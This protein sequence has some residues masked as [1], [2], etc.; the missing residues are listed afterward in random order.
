MKN[1]SGI[2]VIALIIIIAIMLIL[3]TI[4]VVALSGDNSLINKAGEAKEDA[5]I[6]NEKDIINLAVTTVMNNNEF[7][8]LVADDLAAE[9]N[10]NYEDIIDNV[11]TSS[12]SVQVKFKSG[13]M[14]LVSTDGSLIQPTDRTGIEVG[15]YVDYTPDVASTT[16]YP[17]STLDTYSG[18]TNNSADITQD[19]LNWQVLRIYPDGSLDLIGSK[20]S[21]NIYFRGALGYNN[22]V[23][24]MDDICRTLYSRTG[25][26]ITARSVDLEDFDYWLEKSEGGVATRN[27]YSDYGKEK[28]Y[29]SNNK[30]PP[31]YKTQKN[32]SDPG[33]LTDNNYTED[34]D[35]IVKMTY[36]MIDINENNYLDGYIPLTSSNSYWIGSR[37][38]WK[39]GESSAIFGLRY[40]DNNP[41]LTMKHKF[42]SSG[43]SYLNN[44]DYNGYLRPVVHL[45]SSAKITPR[46][47]T[48]SEK[49]H[50]ENY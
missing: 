48:T 35:L 32:E 1:N 34:G 21:Q 7:G 41:R 3:A 22:G 49:H 26:D 31:F 38:C 33:I 45:K 12:D 50:I 29:S 13:R 11:D 40:V 17:H 10:A 46:A 25:D 43:N 15:S 36:Y 47:G 42:Y 19:S 23:Y 9:L 6:K 30:Y 8:E 37:F 39:N 4:S 27:N 2:T 44:N 5:A 18:S 20:T 16:V 28:T 24:L 14:Y